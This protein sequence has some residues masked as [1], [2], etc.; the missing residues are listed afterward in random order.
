MQ[1]YFVRNYTRLTCIVKV[2]VWMFL[3]SSLFEV[4]I[5][6]IAYSTIHMLL[7]MGSDI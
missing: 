6:K 3:C 7:R 5:G 4:C 2:L 1:S